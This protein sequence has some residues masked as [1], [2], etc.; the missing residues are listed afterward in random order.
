MLPTILPTTEEDK[1]VFQEKT[2]YLVG[3]HFRGIKA[4]NALGKTTAIA[5]FDHWTPSSCQIHIWIGNPMALRGHRFVQETF[6]YPFQQCG[7]QLVIGVTPSNLAAAI[8][9]NAHVGMQEVARIKDA[10][11][12][13][14]DMIITEMRPGTCRWL[15]E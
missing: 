6:K 10:W 13:G 4:I 12:I 3:E 5:G 11:D 7:K 8:K 2:G 9:F 1:L 14:V 15:K